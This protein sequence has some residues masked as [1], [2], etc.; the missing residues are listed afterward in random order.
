VQATFWLWVAEQADGLIR[1][2]WSSGNATDRC[3]QALP[4]W[5]CWQIAEQG[6]H[7][8]RD[9]LGLDHFEGRS[10]PG[11]HHHACLVMLAYG[12]LVLNQRAASA[13][14][15]APQGSVIGTRDRW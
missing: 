4:W 6:C 5:R 2:A 10:W 7:W 8:A 15:A 13:P 3:Q 14:R 1:Y 9:R 11:F 12:F